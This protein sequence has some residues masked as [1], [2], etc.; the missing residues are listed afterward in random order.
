MSREDSLATSFCGAFEMMR[1]NSGDSGIDS[2]QNMCRQDSCYDTYPNSFS[3]NGQ[4]VSAPFDPSIYFAHAEGI[5]IEDH[6]ASTLVVGPLQSP[7]ALELDTEVKRG[8]SSPFLPTV[9]QVQPPSSMFLHTEMK[10]DAS[11]DSNSSST[12]RLSRRSQEQVAQ[13]ARPIAPKDE[14][15]RTTSEQPS[16]SLSG[17]QDMRRQRS[18]PEQKKMIPKLQYSRQAKEKLKCE[19]CNR[20]P[21]GYRGSHELRRHIALDHKS[22][23][24]AWVCVDISPDGFLSGCAACDSKK[25]Y[26]Q[27]Y[28]AAAHLRR[29]HFHPRSG[30]RRSKA[31]PNVPK[32][33][34]GGFGGGNDPSLKECRRWLRE[35]Q[36]PGKDYMA[37]AD[38]AVDDNGDDIGE[39][40]DEE[41]QEEQG[42]QAEKDEIMGNSSGNVQTEGEKLQSQDAAVD[43]QIGAS[44]LEDSDSLDLATINGRHFNCQVAGAPFSRSSLESA[45]ETS[46]GTYFSTNAASFTTPT[47]NLAFSP[48]AL[49]SSA[50]VAPSFLS[51]TSADSVQIYRNLAH[52]TPNPLNLPSTTTSNTSPAYALE[53]FSNFQ[54]SYMIGNFSYGMSSS[55]NPQIPYELLDFPPFS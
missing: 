23:R 15:E 9:E 44:P 38:S 20:N 51:S 4:G 47:A 24:T 53:D 52:S 36:V 19:K 13:A 49:S 31:D 41:E 40:D 37:L 21:D 48:R 28:N 1:A 42:E 17:G 33:P 30:V 50:P 26:G 46:L 7:T 10:R 55:N 22:F 39:D 11:S 34:R 43:Q 14:A 6:S 29:F 3:P 8:A 45:Y 35:V 25:P 54:P 16:S 18:A 32:E 27:D 12:S 5:S 2:S